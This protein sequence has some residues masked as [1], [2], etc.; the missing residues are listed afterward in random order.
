MIPNWLSTADE[1][2]AHYRREPTPG[3]PAGWPGWV[4]DPVVKR[5]AEAGI[6]R[7]WA[8]QAAFADLVFS[9][10]HAAITTPTASGKTLA[11]LLPILASAHGVLGVSAGTSPLLTRRRNTALYLAPAKA[12]AHDQ[13]RTARSLGQP[14]WPVITLDGDSEDAERRFAREQA[15]YVLS[16]PDMI[17]YSVLPNHARWSSFLGGL[18]YLVIDEAHRYRGTFG[19]HVAQVIRRLRRVCAGYGA[20]PVVMLASATSPNAASFGGTLIGEDE[21]AVVDTSGA[22]RPGSDVVL[23]Q[24]SGSPVAGTTRLL[25]TLVDEGCQ[26]IAF[27]P[28]RNLAELIAAK[29]SD[30][31]TSGRVVASYRAGYLAGDRRSIESALQDGSLTG[32]A[33]TNALE[34]GVDIAGMDA[35]VVHGFPG[36]RAAMW[37][38]FGR[39]GRAGRDALAVLVA[40]DDPL[41]AYLFAHPESL[42]G[43]GTEHQVLHPDNP[44]VLGPHLAAAAQESPLREDDVRWFGEVLPALADHLVRQGLLRRRPAGWYWTRPDRAVDFISL[45]SLGGRPFEVIERDTGRIIGTVDEAAADKT[46]HEGAVYLHQGEQYVVVDYVRDERSALVVAGRCGYYTQPLSSLDVSIVA[47]RQERPL[48]RGMVCCGEVSLTSQVMGYLRRD[49]VS[50]EVWDQTPLDLPSHTFTTQATWWM[51]PDEVAVRAGVSGVRAGSA[52]H[53]IEHCAIGLLPA[54][55]PCDRW[56]IGGVSLAIHPDTGMTTVFIHDGLPGGAG[57]AWHGFQEADLWL[58]ATLDRLTTCQCDSGCPACVVSPKCGNANQFLDRF[59][60]RDLLAALLSDVPGA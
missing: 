20:N 58:A 16:N 35:V 11:Y 27:V 24:P 53:A 46:L 60:G 22:P 48:G 52:A 5:L 17:H 31:V 7:P 29:A 45:R 55:A 47:T 49:E 43:Q 44:Y 56:D 25:A 40:R 13:F 38:Q 39:A 34:L 57:F 54:F 50:G 26:T 12:L 59:A 3:E 23:W 10:T 51:I 30:Q 19:A 1:L 8:H 21:V 18:R 42:F 41:D 9:G 15:D 4:P 6:E 2:V 14:G 28:S 36:T 37:Q 33:A 32:V